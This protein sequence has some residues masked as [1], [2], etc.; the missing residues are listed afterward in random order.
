MQKSMTSEDIENLKILL[1]QMKV[2]DP[3]FRVFGAERHQYELGPPLTETELQGFEQKHQIALPEDYRI[4][5][6]EAGNGSI[7]HD[8][9]YFMGNAGAGPFYGLASLEEAAQDSDLALPFPFTEATESLSQEEVDRRRDPDRYP[10]APG[11]L[12]LC[13][14][15]SGIVY[16]LV[17]TGESAGTMWEGRENYYPTDISFGAWYRQ[18]VDALIGK[19]PRLAN[20]RAIAGRISLGVSKSE[21]IEICGGSW[22]QTERSKGRSDLS[23]EHLATAFELD[24]NEKLIRIISYSV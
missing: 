9:K 22:K 12:A 20:E 10:G 21:I 7:R 4:F 3:N 24:E 11:A 17:V 18:W 6:K 15:G 13:D 1:A 2:E 14:Y 8:S 23:F 19:L 5:L 16:C